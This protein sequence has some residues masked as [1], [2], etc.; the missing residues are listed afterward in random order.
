MVGVEEGWVSVCWQRGWQSR[1]TKGKL[2]RT[3]RIGR[4]GVSAALSC[5]HRRSRCAGC[6]YSHVRAARQFALHICY[7]GLRSRS[8]C[9]TV[10]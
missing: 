8:M 7:T 1:V 9:E 2:G 3:G 4:A 10:V 5:V 6:E